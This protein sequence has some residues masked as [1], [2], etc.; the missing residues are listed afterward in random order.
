MF[1]GDYLTRHSCFKVLKY[2]NDAFMWSGGPIF[3]PFLRFPLHQLT[4]VQN[5]CDG[6]LMKT[7]GCE[8]KI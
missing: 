6:Q 7:K 3:V 2:H 5:Q 4:S 1:Y 8:L